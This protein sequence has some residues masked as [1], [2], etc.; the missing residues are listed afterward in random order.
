M[1]RGRLSAEKMAT[2]VAA[3]AGG[4]RGEFVAALRPLRAGQA[5]AGL[6]AGACRRRARRWIL[7]D[8][9]RPTQRISDYQQAGVYQTAVRGQRPALLNDFMH[10]TLG[11]LIEPGRKAPWLLLRPSRRCCRRTATWCGPPTGWVSIATRCIS[12]SS[13][14][15][16]DRLPGQPPSVSSQRLGRAGDL[17]FI[18]KPFTGPTMKIINARLRR[19]EALL[20]LT[21]RTG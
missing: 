3:G 13:A 12:A 2:A 7:C 6:P 17:A 8:T 16:T 10:D 21:C 15:K 11:C 4:R 19:Q 14:L 20:P 18:A 1:R 5:V 9:L